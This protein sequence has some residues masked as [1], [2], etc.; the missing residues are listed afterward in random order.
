MGSSFRVHQ[1]SKWLGLGLGLGLGLVRARARIR[2]SC[3]NR[4]VLEHE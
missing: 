4:S 1:P 3:R 2:V